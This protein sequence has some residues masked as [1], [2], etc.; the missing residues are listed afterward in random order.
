MT[1]SKAGKKLRWYGHLTRAHPMQSVSRPRDGEEI[2]GCLGVPLDKLEEV[3][4]ESEVLVAVFRL[5]PT[6]TW[7]HRSE[8]K[9]I[10]D[11]GNSGKKIP[12]WLQSQLC[13]SDENISPTDATSR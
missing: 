9:W 11:G 1:R 13:K 6:K 8:R 7:L 2:S 12:K 3:A 10:L 5:L 4:W